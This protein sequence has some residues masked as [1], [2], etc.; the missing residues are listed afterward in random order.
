MLNYQFLISCLLFQVWNILSSPTSYYCFSSRYS[1]VE[2]FSKI[3]PSNMPFPFAYFH[4][5]IHFALILKF[6]LYNYE[7]SLILIFSHSIISF[8]MYSYH[9]STN[10]C[11]KHPFII[12]GSK[13]RYS[14]K[15][16]FWFTVCQA[17]FQTMQRKQYT[18]QAKNKK[19]IPPLMKV[20]VYCS[21]L[22]RHRV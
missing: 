17:E 19:K 22:G 15:M 10:S 6:M 21:L 9:I 20:L 4:N 13:G 12:G 14:L 11:I 5:F 3:C 16:F 8:A 2:G 1:F 18:K 7:F